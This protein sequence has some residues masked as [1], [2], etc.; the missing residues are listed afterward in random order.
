M[1]KNNSTFVLILTLFT[2]LTTQA[3][4][5]IIMPEFLQKG[6]TVGILATARKIDLETLQP[7][8]KQL[9]SW[10]LKVVIGKT[11]G[12]EQNQLAGPDDLRAQD[13]QEMLD[14][15]NIKAIWGAKGGYGYSTRV[16]LSEIPPGLYVLNL[17]ARSRLGKDIAATRQVQF[18]VVSPVR[19]QQQ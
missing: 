19:G 4:R 6:D 14:N 7:A 5:Q 11:I 12:P 18:R 3:Q 8:I 13:F 1:K 9:E 15:P 2:L 17:E 10:G 16:P